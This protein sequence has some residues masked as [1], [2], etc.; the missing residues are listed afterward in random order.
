ML[1]PLANNMAPHHVGV[2]PRV[3]VA[4]LLLGDWR[5]LSLTGFLMAP[6]IFDQRNRRSTRAFAQMNLRNFRRLAAAML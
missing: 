4:F 3:A 1:L 2:K 5:A 6:P